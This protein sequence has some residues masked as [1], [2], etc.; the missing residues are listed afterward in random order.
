MRVGITVRKIGKNQ[1]LCSMVKSWNIHRR[2]FLIRVVHGQ[3]STVKIQE[4][5]LS[6]VKFYLFTIDSEYVSGSVNESKKKRLSQ[7]TVLDENSRSK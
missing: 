6:T 2:H 3:L 5:K 1:F 4:W 7:K